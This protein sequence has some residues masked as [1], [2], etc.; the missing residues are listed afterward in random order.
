MFFLMVNVHD[1]GMVITVD[2]IQ[3]EAWNGLL[4]V[5]FYAVLPHVFHSFPLLFLQWNSFCHINLTT[6]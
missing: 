1:L 6:Q 5:V 2:L 4:E 3:A